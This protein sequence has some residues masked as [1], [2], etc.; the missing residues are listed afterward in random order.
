LHSKEKGLER[1]FTGMP[2]CSGTNILAWNQSLGF[3]K[4]KKKL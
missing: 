4:A 3:L 1:K 2:I